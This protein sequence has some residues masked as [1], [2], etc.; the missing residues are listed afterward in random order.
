V[1]LLLSVKTE[2]DIEFAAAFWDEDGSTIS[3]FVRFDY[4]HKVSGSSLS[5][6]VRQAW[7]RP[8]EPWTTKLVSGLS[9][10]E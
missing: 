7:Q 1:F 8:W 4:D 3:H 10:L 6:L 2:V 5:P 9:G